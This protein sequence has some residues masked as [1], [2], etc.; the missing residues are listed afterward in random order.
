MRHRIY[1]VTAAAVSL[2]M[3]FSCGKEPEGSGTATRLRIPA[4]TLSDTT[5]TSVTVRWEPVENAACYIYSLNEGAEEMTSETSFIISTPEAGDYTFRAKSVP[6]EGSGYEES[7]WSSTIHYEVKS[8]AVEPVEGL[9]EWLGE[10][11]VTSTARIVFENSGNSVTM[12]KTDEPLELSVSIEPSDEPEYV[13][14]YGLSGAG[15]EVPA[16]ARLYDGGAGKSGL[17]LVVEKPVM[18]DAEGNGISWLAIYETEGGINYVEGLEI[19]MILV[20][21]ENGSA[22]SIPAKFTTESGSLGTVIAADLAGLN[23]QSSV[24][25]YYTEWPVTIPAGEFTFTKIGEQ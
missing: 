15:A 23:G 11:T 18:S 7:F 6:A 16:Y 17:G 1:S 21:D 19:A 5:G 24:S 10:Y 25:L 22:T 20:K 9:E 13:Y 3:L 14:I 12:T 8:A 2:L 4:L